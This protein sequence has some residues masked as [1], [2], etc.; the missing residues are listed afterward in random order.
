[1]LFDIDLEILFHLY[2]FFEPALGFA[3]GF[4]LFAIRTTQK[5]LDE[6]LPSIENLCFWKCNLIFKFFPQKILGLLFLAI[7]KS[8]YS[9]MGLLDISVFWWTK[10]M[11]QLCNLG[12]FHLHLLRPLPSASFNLEQLPYARHYNPQFVY[13]QPT[14]WSSFMYC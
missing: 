3:I 8:H 9:K 1:M 12:G 4:R 13:F 10:M 2:H 7:E 11:T 6:I 14:F 5:T